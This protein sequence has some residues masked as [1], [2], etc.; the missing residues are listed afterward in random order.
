MMQF[1]LASFFASKLS[2]MG[3]VRGAD[4]AL[5]FSSANK[6]T[7]Y[8]GNLGNLRTFLFIDPEVPTFMLFF[9]GETVVFGLGTSGTPFSEKNREQSLYRG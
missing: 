6:L 5:A 9:S 1:V 2:L 7:S 4:F 8:I 3:S